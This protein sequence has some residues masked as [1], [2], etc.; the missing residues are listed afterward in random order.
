[1][2]FPTFLNLSLNYALRSSWSEPQSDPD[3]VVAD[4]I[5]SQGF[6]GGSDGKAMQETLVWSLGQ[7]DSLEKE[8]ATHS[9]TLA[10]KIPWTEEPCKLQS[11][12]SQRIR[13]NERLHYTSLHRVPSSAAK[14]IISL[15]LVLT[16]W[17]CP[18]VEVSLMLLEE[19]VCYD[20]C[21]L[22]TKLC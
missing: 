17:W 12:G 6:L 19:N 1:M 21:I 14:N 16:I 9:S 10:W 20:Q 22:L 11:M 4:C 7:E 13:H 15:I 3:L 2:V 18:C 8:M 5:E